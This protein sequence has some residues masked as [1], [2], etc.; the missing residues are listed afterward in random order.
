MCTVNVHNDGSYVQVCNCKHGSDMCNDEK[1][2]I[3]N[4]ITSN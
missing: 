2:I 3:E 1:R 4:E